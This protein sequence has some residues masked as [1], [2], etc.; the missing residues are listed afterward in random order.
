MKTLKTVW[1]N[2]IFYGYETWTLSLRNKHN[3]TEET[4]D[5]SVEQD[6]KHKTGKVTG[7]GEN[8]ISVLRQV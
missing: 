6:M 5:Q 7:D 4:S 1:K 3:S 8:C 2:V